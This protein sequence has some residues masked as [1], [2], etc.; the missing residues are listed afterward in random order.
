MK[1]GFTEELAQVKKVKVII[2]FS[3]FKKLLLSKKPKGI[4]VPSYSKERPLWNIIKY[5]ED[6]SV[7]AYA[8]SWAERSPVEFTLEKAYQ[9][10]S[11]DE[12]YFLDSSNNN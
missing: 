11:L 12:S 1:I 4:F 3:D 9:T 6:Y 10:M 2:G 5:I 8:D 7:L